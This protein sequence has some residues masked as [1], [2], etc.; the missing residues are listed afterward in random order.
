MELG[1]DLIQKMK[2]Y[3]QIFTRRYSDIVKNKIQAVGWSNI[4][5]KKIQA[6]GWS[7]I[8]K[9]KIEAVGWSDIVKNKIQ[10]VG[11]S[12]ILKN[13]MDTR[14]VMRNCLGPRFQNGF[15]YF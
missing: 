9:N 6:V 12:D 1:T 3:L 11:W 4:V 8:V 2:V 14:H 10:A 15:N 5:K 7:D 13:K